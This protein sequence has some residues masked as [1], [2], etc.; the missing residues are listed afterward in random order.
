[1][2]K[3]II[4]VALLAAMTLVGIET[5][6]AHGGRYFFDRDYGPGY[7]GNYLNNNRG[8]TEE[9]QAAFDKFRNDTAATRREIVVKRSELDALMRQDNPDET[10]VAKLTGD[11]YDLEADLD[12]KADA[13]G[14]DSDNDDYGPGMMR[15]YGWGPGRHMMGW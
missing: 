15:G 14:I 10:K 3:T 12:K 4:A 8:Y 5:V 13:A 6:S 11:L 7:C 9:D 2:K 1:M